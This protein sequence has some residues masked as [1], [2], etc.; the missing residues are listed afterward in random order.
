MKFHETCLHFYKTVK[1][2]ISE[3]SDIP[4]IPTTEHRSRI[5]QFQ[6]SK[7]KTERILASIHSDGEA[8]Y[9]R[10]IQY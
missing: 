6:P 4:I 9:Y 10:N 5:I 8:A 3:Y 7:S 2:S 1:S